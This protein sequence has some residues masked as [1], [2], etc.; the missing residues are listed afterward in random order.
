LYIAE[1]FIEVKNRP[2]TIIKNIYQENI[3]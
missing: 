3:N 2:A 1:I